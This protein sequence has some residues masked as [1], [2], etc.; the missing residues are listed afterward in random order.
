M[1]S[2][3]KAVIA[4]S[5]LALALVSCKGKTENIKEPNTITTALGADAKRLIPMLATD[6]ASADVSG[7]IFN[8]L[9]K[10][11]K[12]IKLT[13][14]LA[15]NWE[16]SPDGLVITFHLRK[17]V[18]WQ[19]GVPFTSADVLFTY[20][21]VKD[22][23][24]AT[25]YSENYGP[26]S[27]VEAPD[28]YTV[29]VTYSEPFAPAVES[30]AMGVIPKHLLEGK[31]VNKDEFN[32]HPIGTGPYKFDE[33]ISGSRIVLKANDTYFEGRPHI[34][35]FVA[36]ILPDE[37]TEFLE[38]KTRGID[39][40]GLTPLQYSRQSDTKD[41][42]EH[43]NKLRYPAFNYTYLGWNLKDERFKDNRVRQA[44]TYAIDQNSI[45]QGVLLGLGQPCTG[46]FPP[47][48]WA[49]NPAVKPY[50]YDPEKA[51]K[52]LA[53]AGWKDVDGDGVLEKD[54]E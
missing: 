54:G 35:K 8:G 32:R 39:Y 47:E 37:A 1:R 10:Y 31:D 5:M 30:W 3:A 26:V 14:D 20:E 33:W 43:F 4:V 42:K 18:K 19:D 51:K 12:D 23:T 44:L 9:V 34:D 22:P 2:F 16:V 50:P 41:I 53:E 52:M 13:G 25:P 38:L 45:I 40:M 49:Y 27:K 36:R 46:P 7:W 48:S 24:V 21:K 17:N 11:D 6:T 28:D 15:E 29:K